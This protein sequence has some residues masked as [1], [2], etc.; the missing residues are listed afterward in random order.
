MFKDGIKAFFLQVSRER[1][2]KPSSY[3]CNTFFEFFSIRFPTGYELFFAA[4]RIYIIEPG[5]PVLNFFELGSLENQ[6]PY[7]LF[8]SPF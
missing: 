3:V 5:F 8:S 1:I 6:L 2:P 7:M 4:T